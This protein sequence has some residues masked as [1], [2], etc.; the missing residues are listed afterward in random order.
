MAEK[1]NI[2]EG[3]RNRVK[4]L[5]LQKGTTAFA[6]HELVELLLFFGIPRKDTNELA[7][8]LLN[9]FGSLSDLMSATYEEL[10]AVPGM[11]PN[12][13]VLI[14]VF[15]GVMNECQR[16]QFSTERLLNTRERLANFAMRLFVGME[17]E[18]V[19]LICMDNK[20]RV[21]AHGQLSE[22]SATA[23]QINTRQA[24]QL[25]LRC[26]ATTVV[27][28]HN[29]PGGLVT[30]S[31]EDIDTTAAMIRLFDQ[32]GVQMVDHVIVA[33]GTHLFMRDVPVC[34]PLFKRKAE[35]SL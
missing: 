3:H 31:R 35:I 6:P 8:R 5:F 16:E 7:H 33:G 21:L 30:P 20:G 18:Q 29:H 27:L 26:N 24:L 12:A 34:A 25:A 10:V 15:N 14:R 11:P 17:T 9:T 1:S 2:H 4:Q 23:A 22:G 19:H 28:T 13:A 32:V